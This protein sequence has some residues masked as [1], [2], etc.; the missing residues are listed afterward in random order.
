MPLV[1][2]RAQYLIYYDLSF[3]VFKTILARTQEIN[4]VKALH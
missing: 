1:K 4:I 3:A 2:Y